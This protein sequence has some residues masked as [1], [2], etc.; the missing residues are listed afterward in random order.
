MFPTDKV[1]V[2]EIVSKL[3]KSN[4]SAGFDDVNVNVFHKVID[5]ILDPFTYIFNLSLASRLQ[6]SFQYLS[7]AAYCLL[8]TIGLFCL[9]S[10]F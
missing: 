7:P 3:I 5:S 4:K 6:K 8:R 10:V 9:T 2:L 1:E